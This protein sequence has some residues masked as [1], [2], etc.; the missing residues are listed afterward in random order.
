VKVGAGPG[1]W[2]AD[3]KLSQGD[4]CTR[5]WATAVSEDDLVV[6]TE[7]EEIRPASSGLGTKT[8][9]GGAL[10]RQC[11]ERDAGRSNKDVYASVT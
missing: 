5:L 11:S 1:K 6:R 2:E 7:P 9:W 3:P 8:C 4:C 10:K